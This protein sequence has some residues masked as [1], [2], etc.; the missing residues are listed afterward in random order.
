MCFIR[1][2]RFKLAS[3]NVFLRLPVLHIPLITDYFAFKSEKREGRENSCVE[4]FLDVGRL[5]SF[6]LL[7][8]HLF[9]QNSFGF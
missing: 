6:Y 9:S 8:L 4:F 1:I 2:S 7:S 5:C 3:V